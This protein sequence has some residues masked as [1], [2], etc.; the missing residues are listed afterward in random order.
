M[1]FLIILL[2]DQSGKGW[3]IG[4]SALEDSKIHALAWRFGMMNTVQG[5]ILPVSHHFWT[6]VG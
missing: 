3:L 6:Y 4:C 2:F 1:F 5:V